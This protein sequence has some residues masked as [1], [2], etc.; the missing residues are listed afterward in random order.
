MYEI[1][2]LVIKTGRRFSKFFD[3]PQE[4][5]LWIKK[6]HIPYTDKLTIVARW[7]H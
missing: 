2:V 5:D 7:K 4:R 3:T 1:V 6:H